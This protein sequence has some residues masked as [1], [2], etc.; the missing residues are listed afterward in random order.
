[1]SR[2]FSYNDENF[3]VIG[4]VLFVH[5]KYEDAANAGTRLIR[6]PPEIYNRLLFLSCMGMVAYSTKNSSSFD[7]TLSVVEYNKDCYISTKTNLNASK[8]R[9]I[10]CT[11]MLKDI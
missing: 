1:M 4:N 10:Y 11:Y 9:Y 7:V 6:I 2:P 5:F 3:T 8:N